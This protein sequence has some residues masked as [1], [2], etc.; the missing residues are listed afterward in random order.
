MLTSAKKN[1]LLRSILNIVRE[2]MFLLLAVACG[3]YFFLGDTTEAIMMLVSIAF[4]AGIEI[5]QETKSEKAL[6]ALREFTEANVRVLR[7][8]VWTKLPAAE[9]VPDDAVTVGEGERIPADGVILK[10]HDLSV[11]EAVLTGESL[12]VD[13]KAGE[14]LFQGTTVAAGQGV[15]RVISTGNSTELGKLGKSIEAMDPVPTPLQLQ[16]EKFVRQ[17]GIFGIIA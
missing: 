5:F 9:L 1:H 7:D 8:G 11:E 15:F 14:N 12:A 4:V 17:M 10:Q 3:L 13:K 2:P 16:L 6:E